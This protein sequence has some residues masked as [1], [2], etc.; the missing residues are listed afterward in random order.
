MSETRDDGISMSKIP[1]YSVS[2]PEFRFGRRKASPTDRPIDVM[3]NLMKESPRNDELAHER[4]AMKGGGFRSSDI[5]HDQLNPG[6]PAMCRLVIEGFAGAL[7]YSFSSH[8]HEFS[9]INH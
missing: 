4:D 2:A 8:P 7:G 3:T 9:R 5:V 1:P 6:L